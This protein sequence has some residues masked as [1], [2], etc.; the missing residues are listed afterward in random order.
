MWVKKNE[1]QNYEKCR[2]ILL[3]K[4]YI[5]FMLT[6]AY[7]SDVSDASGMQ[8]MDIRGRCWSDEI[9]NALG[10][11]KELLAD[12]YESPEVSG[13]VNS[14][15]VPDCLVGAPVAAGAGDNAA[16]A[17]GTAVVSGGRAFTTIGTSGV[18][19]AHC[20]EPLIDPLGR[21]HTFCSAVP[22]K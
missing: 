10:I 16:A 2:H 7:A 13:Y 5:R 22:G 8:L 4:D 1:P 15:E 19:F 12:I 11:Q 20:D 9:L 21:I 14:K 17:V 3:P 6:G 18:V